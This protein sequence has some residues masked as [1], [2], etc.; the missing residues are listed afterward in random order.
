MLINDNV[1]Y[2]K[3]EGSTRQGETVSAPDRFCSKTRKPENGESLPK[4]ILRR[5]AM[6]FSHVD[7]PEA[8]ISRFQSDSVSP[9]VEEELAPLRRYYFFHP[10]RNQSFS[11][12][13]TQGNGM[14]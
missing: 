8:P 12:E 11:T 9:N 10:H 7:Q 1:H 5:D 4:V 13:T 6:Q 14:D 3:L 2:H